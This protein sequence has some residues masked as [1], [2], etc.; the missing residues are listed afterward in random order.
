[1]ANKIYN[2]MDLTKEQE[3]KI[4]KILNENKKIQMKLIFEIKELDDRICWWLD[5]PVPDFASIGNYIEDLYKK[6]KEQIKLNVKTYLK[7]K[8]ELTGEQKKQFVNIKKE[9]QVKKMD[10]R[11]RFSGKSDF[12]MNNTVGYP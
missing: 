11:K 3:K 1:M 10:R 5:E 9:M 2:K 8:N 6:K 4:N 12:G 7:I